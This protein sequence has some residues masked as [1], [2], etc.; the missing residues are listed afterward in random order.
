MKEFGV[1][2]IVVTRQWSNK[3][4]NALDYISASESK[5]TLIEQTEY[6]TIIRAPYF[7]SISNR[8][9][10]KYGEQKFTFLR[11]ALTA[12]DEFRQFIT[13]SGPKKHLYHAANDYLKHNKVDAIIA[14]GDPFVTFY[15]AKKLGAKY[16]APWI[17]D[18][19]DDWISNHV[20]NYKKTFLTSLM[21]DFFKNN[22]KK[23]IKSV[24]GIISVSDFLVL[25]IKN[26]TNVSNTATIENGADL[27][28][29]KVDKSPYLKNDFNIL[30]SGRLYDMPYLTDFESGL[31][32]F[33][34]TLNNKAII[35]V[36]FIGTEVNENMATQQ[37]AKMKIKFPENIIIEKS[38]SSSEIAQYQIHAH[39]LLN[40]IAGD[41]EKGLIGAKSYNYAIT[42]NP[43]LTIPNIKNNK[44]VFFP[45]RDIQFIALSAQDVCD[46][47]NKY[48]Y[49][50][51]KGIKWESSLTEIEKYK[52]SRR[53]STEKLVKFIFK[54]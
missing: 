23:I 24:N 29:Y 4:G 28:L 6:G 37:L 32:K 9:L 45:N 38:K 25:Q 3:H 26:R 36:Y 54:K 46:F 34:S 1:E 50:F 16:N 48:Y 43:I 7:P 40:L 13:I 20:V 49:L 27:E 2:P 21:N 14:T 39:I 19:R 42:K 51:K 15:F 35:K 44:S 22:E 33:F 47:L 11:R 30:Y 12:W 31:E 5:E 8:I 10:L 18:Y 53:Y 52:L 17:A 41:P